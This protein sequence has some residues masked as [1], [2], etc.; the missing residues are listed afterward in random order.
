VQLQIT[1]MDV[2]VFDHNDHRMDL[3]EPAA[4]MM[5]RQA[6]RYGQFFELFREYRDVITGVTFWGAADD[7]TW[8]DYFPVSPRK[9]WPLLF[10]T[11]HRPKPAFRNVIRTAS[12]AKG[13]GQ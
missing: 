2:S 1:E 3:T 6:E 4:D 13:T 11:G 9:N 8:L 10:N 5:E 12:T 7:Y